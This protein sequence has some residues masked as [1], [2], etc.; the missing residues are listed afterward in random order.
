MKSHY[1]LTVETLGC[2]L[3]QAESES[4][5]RRLQQS[6]LRLVSDGE[7]ADIYVLNTCTVTGIADR[8][9]RHR[10]R[11]IRRSNPGAFI[12]AVGCY[13]ER[14]PEELRRAGADL[15]LGNA[16]KE[17]LP[18]L[19]RPVIGQLHTHFDSGLAREHLGRTRSMVKIQS[20][21][22]GRCAF[23][24]VPQVRGVESSVPAE[25]VI[26]EVMDKVVEGYRE[27]VLT[28]TNLGS[29][30]CDGF[31]LESLIK[32]ILAQTRLER[33]R[34]SSLYPHDVTPQLLQ[35]WGDGRMCNHLHMALQSGSDVVLGRMRRRYS[36][37]DF[38]RAVALARDEIPG[39][40]ITT[41]VLVGFPGEG[42]AEFDETFRF[43]ENTGFAR[44][45]V[46]PFSVRPE[47]PAAT[48]DGRV[49]ERTKDER[50]RRMLALAGRSAE[51]FALQ[52]TGQTLSV[53]WEQEVEPGRWRGLTGNYLRV[54]AS[55]KEK[56]GG[57][58]TPTK[59]Q[60]LR[61]GDLWGEVASTIEVPCC[62]SRGG[63]T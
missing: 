57:Q 33:L 50:A 16:E 30:R 8:K 28:G 31:G 11:Q 61:D 13:A 41:D 60:G 29:Y 27:V 12:A 51:R 17:R 19:L 26:Q 18:E 23:C 32:E 45:H 48:M 59:L 10:V 52:F 6:G 14:A 3:N 44:I 42:E 36:T 7:Q 9:A 58:L 38:A 56:L 54:V 37:A 25:Q 35:L 63:D 5:G 55:S 2:K 47:T 22:N 34:V 1:S 20:G 4:L 43:C 24:I 15:I 21:C 49:D 39:V 53:L 62:S 40:A 46:F